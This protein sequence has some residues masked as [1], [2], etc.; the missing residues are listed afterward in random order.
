[1][2]RSG[3]RHIQPGTKQEEA[4]KGPPALPYREELGLTGVDN[5]Q[6]EWEQLEGQSDSEAAWVVDMDTDIGIGT[7]K[8]QNTGLGLHKESDLAG[9]SS[10]SHLQHCHWLSSLSKRLFVTW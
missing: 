3:Q 5:Q 9:Y 8:N 10:D 7:G 6:A 2:Q 4:G 1:M